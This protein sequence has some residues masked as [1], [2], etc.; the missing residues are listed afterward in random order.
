MKKNDTFQLEITD[1]GIGGEGIGKYEGMTFFVKGALPGDRIVAGVTKLKKTYGYARVVEIIEPSPNRR[2]AVCPVS[3]K[4]GGCQIMEMDYAAQLRF[5]Q[6]KVADDLVR[7]GGFAPDKVAAVMQP[8]IG[9]EEPYHFRN[10]AQYPVQEDAEGNPVAGF[11]AL[12]S[13]RVIEHENCYLGVEVNEQIL[14]IVK[15]YM[16]ANRVSAYDETTGKGLIRHVLI[17]VGFTSK[18]VMVCLVI[19]GST[20]PVAGAL[21]EALQQVEG[22]TSISVNSNT[23]RDNVILGNV[24]KTLWGADYI[25][26]SIGGVQFQIQPRSFYQVNPVQTEKLYGKALE[27][28]NLT[29]EET[30]WDLYCGIGTI[31]L[32]LAKKAKMVYGV[33]I[34]PEAI[35]DAKRNAALNHIT[36]ARFYVGKAEEVLPEYYEQGSIHGERIL[37]AD[38]TLKSPDVIVVDPPRKGCDEMCLSTMLRMAP[39]RIVYVSCDPATLARDLK[40]LCAEDYQLEAVTPVDQFCHSMH[41]ECVVLMSK[42]DT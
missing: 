35:E 41:V 29:G 34:V 24:T 27:Y 2:E 26:D 10:K 42:A 22:M 31:S 38:A 6:Q 4:C 3:G 12:R 33:E 39:K 25:T 32:F 19:N 11:Y 37:E 30:V 20:L 7:I 9:M 16:R 23:R 15:D 14:T 5:K 21:V 40:I 1:L 13:H 18:E 28:A 17:R 8:I 36:N